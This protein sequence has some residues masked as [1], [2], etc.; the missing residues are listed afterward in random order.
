LIVYTKI[1]EDLGI[2]VPLFAFSHCTA[3]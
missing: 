3:W 2:E 1:C